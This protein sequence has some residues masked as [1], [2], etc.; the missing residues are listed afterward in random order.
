MGSSRPLIVTASVIPFSARLSSWSF[1]NDCRGEM[2]TDSPCTE[3]PSIKAG[4]WNVSD[5]P[6]PVGKMAST[7]L[8]STAARAARSC[9]GS[10][11]YVRNSS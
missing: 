9:S 10:P 5:L 2:T 6:P 3:R 8:R 11:S 4:N 7:D 1:I